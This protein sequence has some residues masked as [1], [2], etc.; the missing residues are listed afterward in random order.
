MM[1]TILA[2]WMGSR[3]LQWALAALLTLSGYEGWKYHQRHIG[4]VQ[5]TAKIEQKTEKVIDKAIQDSAPAEL[6]GAAVR[7]RKSYCGNC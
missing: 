2:A 5:Q 1:A 6:P 4:A 3:P 7:L